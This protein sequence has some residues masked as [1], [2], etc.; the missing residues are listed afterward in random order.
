MS[1]PEAGTSQT[2][3]VHTFPSPKKKRL[4]TGPLSSSE[5]QTLINVFKYVEETWPKECFPSKTDI[6][7][8]TGEIMGMS[9]P[10]V[11]RVINQYKTLHRVESPPPPAR[12]PSQIDS[13]DDMDLAAVRRKVH[14]FF[15]S[16]EMPT[17]EKVMESVNNDDS[18]PNI[19]KDVMC[20]L[21]KKL[22]FKYSKR[23]RKSM[24]IDKP[25]IAVWRVKY[26]NE[27]AKYRRDGKKIYYLDETWVN[28]GMITTLICY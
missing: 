26:L 13:F 23:S 25:D 1:E 16:N 3:F 8:K 22:G 6:V 28:E 14:M 18:L 27:I 2:N 12:K 10:T 15:F 4:K 21:M 24:L 9:V 7:Q 5:K 20:K 17:I 11:Y 19:K